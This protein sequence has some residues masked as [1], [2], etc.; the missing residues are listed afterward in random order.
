M[1]L[2]HL[3]A[4]IVVASTS[5]FAGTSATNTN[6]VSPTLQVTANVQKAIR[7][8]LATG[9]GCTVNAGGSTDYAVDFGTVDALGVNT[10]ACG[11]RFAPATPGVTN[12]VYYTDYTLT[13]MFTSQAVSTNT[14]TAYVSTNFGMANL[15]VVQSNTAPAA[16]TDLTPMSTSVAAQTSVQANATTGTAITRYVGVA[17]TPSNGAGLTGSSSATITYTLT[18]N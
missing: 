8:T 3:I 11:S 12:A 4:V 6:T 10:G 5:A 13:P 18:V 2:R 15:S 1:R 14:I 9:T 16:V 17:V 7:L